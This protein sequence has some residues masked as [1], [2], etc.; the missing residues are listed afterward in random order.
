MRP[1]AKHLNIK[2]HLREEVQGN[3]YEIMR[4]CD[5]TSILSSM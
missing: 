4:G 1:K 5:P 2:Y 3:D